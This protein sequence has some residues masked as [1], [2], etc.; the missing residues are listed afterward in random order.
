MNTRNF[1]PHKLKGEILKRLLFPM[2]VFR[3]L[4]YSEIKIFLPV[5][6][7]LPEKVKVYIMLRGRSPTAPLS[8]VTLLKIEKCNYFGKSILV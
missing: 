7:Y 1:K 3:I 6:M 2:T 4:V 8:V 5:K